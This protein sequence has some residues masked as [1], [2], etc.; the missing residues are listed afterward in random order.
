[1]PEPDWTSWQ[2]CSAAVVGEFVDQSECGLQAEGMVEFAI[3]LCEPH[4]RTSFRQFPPR[5]RPRLNI[6]YKYEESRKGSD[7]VVEEA[8]ATEAAVEKQLA[9][10]RDIKLIKSAAVQIIIAI[11]LCIYWIPYYLYYPSPPELLS[12]ERYIYKV[13]VV[14]LFLKLIVYLI[15]TM[16]KKRCFDHIAAVSVDHRL[17]WVVGR[18]ILVSWCGGNILPS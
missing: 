15:K 11:F 14:F 13:F 9:P 1:M 12:L 5:P 16:N 10:H 18:L 8:A 4:E 3:M 6:Y 2:S 7:G 17:W